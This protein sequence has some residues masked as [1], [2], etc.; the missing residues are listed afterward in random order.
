MSRFAPSSLGFTL[1][2]AAL[3]GLP[4]LSTDV[5]RPALDAADQQDLAASDQQGAMVISLFFAGFERGAIVLRPAV[6]RIGR[7]PVLIGSMALLT[8]AGAGCV[9]SSSIT[10]LLICRFIH[11]IG[12]AGGTV[13]AFAIVRD[14]Y[15]GAAA[16]ARL[17]RPSAWCSARRRS[18][19]RR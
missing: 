3:A 6:D 9:L 18:W 13:L 10:M 8:L 15:E 7:R 12:A 16:R 2:I 5:L 14:V 19:R 11:G 4:P 1:L 17:A